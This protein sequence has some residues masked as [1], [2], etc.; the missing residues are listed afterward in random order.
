M[1]EVNRKEYIEEFGRFTEIHI[2]RADDS[3]HKI[4]AD[5]LR[6]TTADNK[7]APY[8]KRVRL[9]SAIYNENKEVVGED[10]RNLQPGQE[11]KVPPQRPGILFKA[12][13]DSSLTTLGLIIKHHYADWLDIG[14][15][16][17]YARIKNH[18]A[19]HKLL[20]GN[21]PTFPENLKLKIPTDF[22]VYLPEISPE[23][24]KKTEIPYDFYQLSIWTRRI[25][26]LKTSVD[27]TVVLLDDVIG[28]LEKGSAEIVSSSTAQPDPKTEPAPISYT[29]NE[30]EKFELI[31]LR[32]L[33]THCVNLTNFVDTD[34]RKAI[35]QLLNWQP[36]RYRKYPPINLIRE[37]LRRASIDIE[38]A[39][40]ALVQRIG[41]QGIGR[42]LSKQANMLM[43]MDKIAFKAL[44]PFRDRLG[45]DR[46]INPIT[47]FSENTHIRRVPHTNNIIL[48]GVSYAHIAAALDTE[49]VAQQ[50]QLPAFELMAIP[51]EVGHFIYHHGTLKKEPD[52]K[53]V[54]YITEEL[55][56]KAVAN[57]AIER[58]LDW[59]EEVFAD[60]YGCYVSG[61]L[62]AIGLQALILTTSD[63][64]MEHDDG[65]H[66]VPIMRPFI[67]SMILRKLAKAKLRTDGQ[68]SASDELDKNWASLLQYRGYMAEVASKLDYEHMW[69]TLRWDDHPHQRVTVQRVLDAVEPIVDVSIALLKDNACADTWS[70]QSAD[71][72]WLSAEIPWDK[73]EIGG[74][75]VG[76]DK[77]MLALTNATFAGKQ[78][79][80]HRAVSSPAD[81]NESRQ[82]AIAAD[83]A[84]RIENSHDA[85]EVLLNYFEDWGDSG[86]SAF[87]NHP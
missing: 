56:E 9:V 73:N 45:K 24:G 27:E 44:A 35:Q 22:E 54:D 86:P 38:I 19:N 50:G 76:Y 25:D 20:E 52:E 55:K 26:S 10:R 1:T 78:V 15:W 82:P 79:P 13:D 46:A 40:R 3:L 21:A 39:Q 61:V 41:V 29:P 70:E 7:S 64:F 74:N 66:P 69:V 42:K 32:N 72:D 58:Y 34:L 48:L 5:I 67:I 12:V 84:D 49:V 8:D 85:E 59:T 4:A 77:A 87:G 17:I 36:R 71:G 23:R 11:L 33:R 18:P 65:E 53:F 63:H 47:Y 6:G 2:V 83:D 62:T 30:D 75:L 68:I 28:Q 60:V 16:Q 81:A 80:G 51:H 31:Q 37:A 43:V 57:P 14:P